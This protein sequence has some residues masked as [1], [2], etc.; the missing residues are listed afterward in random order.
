MSDHTFNQQRASKLGICCGTIN[1]VAT[2]RDTV[3]MQLSANY[4][5]L[6]STV[7]QQERG[8]KNFDYWDLPDR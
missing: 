5:T 8:S 3:T 1:M 6:C 4:R 2:F 7:Y